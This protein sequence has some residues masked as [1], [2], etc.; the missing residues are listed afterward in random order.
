MYL[1]RWQ[2]SAKRAERPNPDPWTAWTGPADK[3][4]VHSSS[5]LHSRQDERNNF[6]YLD[7]IRIIFLWK[8]IY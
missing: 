6:I 2:Q 4:S 3:Q 1:F 5:A 8:Y 7:D